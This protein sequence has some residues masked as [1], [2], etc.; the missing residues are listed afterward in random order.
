MRNVIKIKTTDFQ[1]S[2]IKSMKMQLYLIINFT[3]QKVG[4]S[5]IFNITFVSKDALP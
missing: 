4:V 2:M 3:V 5:K 1:E